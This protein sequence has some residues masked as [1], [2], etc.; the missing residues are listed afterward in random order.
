MAIYKLN[1]LTESFEEELLNSGSDF[2]QD[3]KN[4]YEKLGGSH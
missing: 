2:F 1:K 3:Y 4:I